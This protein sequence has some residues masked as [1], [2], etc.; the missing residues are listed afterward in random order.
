MLVLLGSC[1]NT[2]RN[3]H[4]EEV[5]PVDTLNIEKFALDFLRSHPDMNNNAITQ[6]EAAEDFKKQFKESVDKDDLLKDI[7]V[8]LRS[9]KDQ[10][11]GKYTAHFYSTDLNRDMIS[12][13]KGIN[14]DYA[15]TISKDV[16]VKL[17]EQSKY[18]IDVAYVG[19]IDNIDMF[20][21]IVGYN[22]W[23]QTDEVGLGPNRD[24]YNNS[25]KDYNIN[26]GLILA[27]LKNIK[28]IH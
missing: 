9:L 6:K 4:S 22:D 17:K 3:D 2:V 25:I 13:F 23:V 26:L 15:V 11:N 8:S 28:A 12:P 19:H 10:K 18:I 24:S 21:R 14:M 5:E 20:Q 16:A 27:D 7:P 1:V